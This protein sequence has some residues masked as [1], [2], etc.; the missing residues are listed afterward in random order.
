MALFKSKKRWEIETDVVVV[1]TG[2][3]GLT[4]ALAAKSQGAEILC[5]RSRRKSAARPRSRAA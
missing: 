3:A 1:G 2:G 4:A 5:S